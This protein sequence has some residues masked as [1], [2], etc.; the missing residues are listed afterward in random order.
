M[1]FVQKAA[2]QVFADINADSI[3]TSP[4]EGREFF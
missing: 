2:G 1:M 4:D 3:N